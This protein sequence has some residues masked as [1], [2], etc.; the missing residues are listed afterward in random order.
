MKFI[1]ILSSLVLAITMSAT[2]ATAACQVGSVSE[3]VLVDTVTDTD[4]QPLSNN[5]VVV[6][7]ATGNMLSVRADTAGTVAYVDFEFDGGFVRSESIFPFAL[8]S[9]SQLN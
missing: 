2:T 9:T 6:L 7:A 1:S 4:V 8:V 3:F 5:A